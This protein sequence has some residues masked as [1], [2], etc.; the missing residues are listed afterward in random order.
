MGKGMIIG[1]ILGLIAVFLYA[2]PATLIAGI[3][4]AIIGA[5]SGGVIGGLS[6]L[7]V[8]L[9]LKRSRKSASP[10]PVDDID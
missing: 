2:P 7:I 8:E 5:I 10:N 6:G 9:S 4:L 1:A 3:N